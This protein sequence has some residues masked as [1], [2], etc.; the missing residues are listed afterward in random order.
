MACDVTRKTVI[1]AEKA[2][3]IPEKC[4]VVKLIL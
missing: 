3:V 1:L 2:E 4:E